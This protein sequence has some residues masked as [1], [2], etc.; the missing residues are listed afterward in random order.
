MERFS[1]TV[2]SMSLVSAW[3]ITPIILLNRIRL[4]RNIMSGN[5]RFAAG[6]RNERCHHADERALTR[7]IGSEQAEDLSVAHVEGYVAHG[8]EVAVALYDVFDGDRRS[9]C[10]GVHGFTS[11]SFGI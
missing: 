7:A 1:S 11:L 5:D 6:D 10:A 8:F 9:W 3:G 2:R 4:F